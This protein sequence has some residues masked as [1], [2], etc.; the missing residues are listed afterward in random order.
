M[1]DPPVM[2]SPLVWQ[3]LKGELQLYLEIEIITTVSSLPPS[4]ATLEFIYGLKGG[5]GGGGADTKKTFIR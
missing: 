4:G 2:Y 1:R 3:M 5:G